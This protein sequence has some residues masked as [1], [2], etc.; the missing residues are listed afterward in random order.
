MKSFKFQR[1]NTFRV[2]LE[3]GWMHSWKLQNNNSLT[4]KAEKLSDNLTNATNQP[5]TG[6]NFPFKVFSWNSDTPNISSLVHINPHYSD[7][8]TQLNTA[9]AQT[10]HICLIS[11]SLVGQSWWLLS[12]YYGLRRSGDPL[13]NE[14]WAALGEDWPYNVLHD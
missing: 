1:R 10:F 8:R 6:H 5:T 9:I 13:P 14:T 12:T 3:T 2:L 7:H 4:E 11:Q